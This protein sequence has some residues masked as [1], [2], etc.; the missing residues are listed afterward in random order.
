MTAKKITGEEISAAVVS[1]LP[2]RPTAP[3]SIGGRGYT[4]REIKEA[5]D[6]LP[7]LIAERYNR[8][9]DDIGALGKNSL[10][11][12]IKTG[13]EEGHNLNMLFSDIQSGKILDY[14]QF[15]GKSVS[16][17]LAEIKY[18]LGEEESNE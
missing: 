14:I 8:L 7:L 9:I 5:F 10:A 3:S 18:K 1:S 15:E 16:S 17:L 11:G 12:E 13:I 4:A 6:K 2:T